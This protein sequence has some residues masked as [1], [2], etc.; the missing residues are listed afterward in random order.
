MDILR[1]SRQVHTAQI[2]TI[3]TFHTAV[4]LK[5]FHMVRVTLRSQACHTVY[6]ITEARLK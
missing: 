1:L 4:L 5:Y 3:L 2:L 6:H